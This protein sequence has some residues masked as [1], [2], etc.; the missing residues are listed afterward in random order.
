MKEI[1]KNKKAR[2]TK[3]VRS[4]TFGFTAKPRLSVFR[5]N[6]FIYA[7]IIDDEKQIT[8]VS[9]RGSEVNEEKNKTKVSFAVGQNIA[10]RALAKKIKKIVFDRG[11][12][13]FHGRIKALAEGARKAGLE[14]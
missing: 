12:Y 7:Q 6:R 4:R 1:T 2:R 13:K 5:S 10:Q 3:R 11:P 8:L 14:F 9:A